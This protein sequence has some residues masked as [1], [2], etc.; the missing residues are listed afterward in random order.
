[1]FAPLTREDVDQ[2][3]KLQFEAIAKMIEASGI[4][5]SASAEAI[6]WLSELGFDP[7]FGARPVKR[8]LQKK[9]LNEL[10]KQILAGKVPQSGKVVV[11]VFDKQIVFREPIKEDK[12]LS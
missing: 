3:V 5:L 9:V 12:A 7:Q 1:M 4:Q 2:I 10:S 6:N 11:D 8:V